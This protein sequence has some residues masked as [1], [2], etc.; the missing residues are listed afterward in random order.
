M[1]IFYTAVR[2]WNPRQIG[3]LIASQSISGIAVQ[4]FVG[5]WIDESRHQRLVTAFSG[6]VVA[7]GAL[8]IALGPGYHAPYG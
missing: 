1:S 7:L 6:I 8:G 4:G 3:I 2:H 5:N